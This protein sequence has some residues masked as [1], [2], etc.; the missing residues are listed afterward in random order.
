MSL[1][2]GNFAKDFPIAIGIA[3]GVTIAALIL[4]C[5]LAHFGPRLCGLGRKD[6]W[7]SPDIENRNTVSEACPTWVLHGNTPIP[8]HRDRSVTMSSTLEDDFALTT[9]HHP[10]DNAGNNYDMAN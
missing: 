10:T 8:N 4:I 2:S 7:F 5:G 6:R 9:M 3:A 1:S